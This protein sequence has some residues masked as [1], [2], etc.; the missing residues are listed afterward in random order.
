MAD[1][2]IGEHLTDG[3]ITIKKLFYVLRPLLACRWIVQNRDAAA[4][5]I[6]KT[7]LAGLGQSRGKRRDQKSDG[8][9]EPGRRGT[10]RRT[11]CG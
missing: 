11:R 9:E 10:D 5:G 7:N 6:R 2:A 8:A 3:R 1:R 4:N